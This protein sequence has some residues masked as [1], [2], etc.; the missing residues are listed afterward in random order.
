MSDWL[1]PLGLS[2]DLQRRLFATLLTLL[3]LWLGR[4]VWLALVYR[5]VKDAWA[6]YRWRKGTSYVAVG[7]GAVLVGRLWLSGL[8][9]LATFFGLLSA[10]LAIA[11]KDLVAN[12]AG[13][14]YIVW[15]RPFDV[16]DR[17]QIGQH[18]GDVI[19]IGV[20]Q[21]TLNEIGVWV[22][23]DQSTGR[24]IHVPN[25][26]VLAEPVANYHQGFPY[27]WHEIPVLVT[28]E[29]NWRRAKEILTRIAARHA[30]HLTP[31]A[32]RHLLDA[33]RKYLIAYAKLT[34]IVYTRVVEDGVRLTIRYLVEPR[35][36]RGT[37]QA[38]WEDILDEFSRAPDIQFAY[39]TRRGF[40]NLAE[41]KPALRGAGGEAPA[42]LPPSA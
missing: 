29:S 19:D 7:L 28:F 22:Q 31:E 36:R 12:L 17:I 4:R 35:R 2:P 20:F 25:G 11:L 27:L 8:G 34:P 37:E 15:R 14:L 26:R 5:R 40:N 21:F 3:G 9:A 30:E 38:I 42:N 39:I 32:E 6:R 1:Q 33:S 41:G 23:A 18:A 13:W 16:G 24:I 10:G